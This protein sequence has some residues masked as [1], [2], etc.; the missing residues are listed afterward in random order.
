[1]V[2]L[3]ALVETRDRGLE[4]GAVESRRRRLGGDDRGDD[5]LA[6]LGPGA[7]DEQAGGVH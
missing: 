1:V 5:G 2:G 3:S 7:G 4:D 6:D